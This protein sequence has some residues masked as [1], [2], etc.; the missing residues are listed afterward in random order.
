MLM[1]KS[2]SSLRLPDLPPIYVS[3][4]VMLLLLVLCIAA[5]GYSYYRFRGGRGLASMI[6][7][8]FPARRKR[9][10]DHRASI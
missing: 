7:Q 10:G 2:G 9:P 8:K 6:R 1:T 5:A 4:P 3:R